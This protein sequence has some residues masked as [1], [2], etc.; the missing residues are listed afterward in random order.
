MNR[1]GALKYL[2]RKIRPQN[3]VPGAT[4]P[5]LPPTAIHAEHGLDPEMA[6]AGPIR[7]AKDL[8]LDRRVFTALQESIERHNARHPAWKIK[9][10]RCM[11]CS[12]TRG[13]GLRAIS[14]LDGLTLYVENRRGT[15]PPEDWTTLKTDLQTAL[16][17]AGI[18]FGGD[19]DPVSDITLVPVD[20]RQRIAGH[21]FFKD[22]RRMPKPEEEHISRLVLFRTDWRG[23]LVEEQQN[24]CC[25]RPGPVLSTYEKKRG[26]SKCEARL[27]LAYLVGA[28]READL[29]ETLTFDSPQ[30]EARLVH[31]RRLRQRM[32]DFLAARPVLSPAAV[33]LVRQLQPAMAGG[34]PETALTGSLRGQDPKVLPRALCELLRLRLIKV[35]ATGTGILPLWHQKLTLLVDDEQNRIVLPLPDGKAAT[36]RRSMLARAEA[37]AW[38]LDKIRMKS[39]PQARAATA[40]SEHAVDP[41]LRDCA[42]KYIGARMESRDVPLL[43]GVLGDE[44]EVAPG[45]AITLLARADIPDLR[46]RL[47]RAMDEWRK[48]EAFCAIA[49]SVLGKRAYSDA[50]ERAATA[51]FLRQVVSSALNRANV[52]L[53][54]C[55]SGI[56]ALKRVSQQDPQTQASVRKYV[57]EIAAGNKTPKIIVGLIRNLFS[58]E[59]GG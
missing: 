44:Y 31:M 47:C 53:R 54:V 3:R 26:L 50:R 52:E 29:R 1:V 27:R 43:I 8:F 37:G 19:Y 30:D 33:N 22:G 21:L 38:R 42:V 20:D 18:H 17:A 23:R 55:Y 6:P 24:T 36:G 45:S 15:V 58:A 34:A 9:E 41:F 51:A 11:P 46:E 4:G 7:N 57:N 25:T 40:E 2:F 39:L 56:L 14:D 49:I 13:L 35:D 48:N 16:S 32:F 59:A 28:L 10:V 5:K 12:V